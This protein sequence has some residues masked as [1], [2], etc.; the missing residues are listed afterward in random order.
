MFVLKVKENIDVGDRLIEKIFR[1]AKEN[2][3]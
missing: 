2:K 3:L 1:Q